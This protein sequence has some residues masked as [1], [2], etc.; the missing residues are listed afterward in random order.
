MNSRSKR[1]DALNIKLLLSLLV[2]S[3]VVLETNSLAQGGGGTDSLGTG[4]RNTIQG[5][6]YLPSGRQVDTRPKVRLESNTF[7]N[8]S[9][10]ADGDGHFRFNNVAAGK[11]TLVVEAGEAYEDVREE[12]YIE[13]TSTLG[14]AINVPMHPR[15]VMVPIY[16]QPKRG[17]SSGVRPGVINAA[18]ADV[19]KAAADAYI[20]ALQD[21]QKGD[22]KSAITELK[23]ATS[24]HAK[25][26]LAFN[27][28]GVQYLKLG[29]ADKAVEALTE[30]VRLAP[31]DFSPRL[32]YG[33]A[34]LNQRKVN[35]AE[36]QLRLALKLNSTSPTAHMYLGL[37]LMNQKKLD[38]AQKELELAVSS[39]TAE[40]AVA[41]KYLG[42]I[43]W[44]M[45][46]YKKAADELET[47][48]K[49]LPNA[50]D[51]ERTRAAIKDLKSRQ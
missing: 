23:T 46:N 11:Y 39:N 27:E 42:G 51:A 18:L 29:Q 34:L 15:T 50:P 36:A 24:L 16:L 17:T 4:G 19:P 45:R 5:R 26:P 30:A 1:T 3:I 43:Y 12:V 48:I 22:T 2:A 32:N 7:S 41:H 37:A 20:R 13:G 31:E 49:L 38:D 10:I 21:S 25:F 35:E 40:V 8:L 14:G 28:L 9:V 44:G 47:Y 6:I 33:I